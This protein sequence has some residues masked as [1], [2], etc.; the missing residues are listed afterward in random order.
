MKTLIKAKHCS[1]N[2]IF[3]FLRLKNTNNVFL[4]YVKDFETNG[5]SNKYSSCMI[6]YSAEKTNNANDYKTNSLFYIH[7][8]I[9]K[10]N[11]KTFLFHKSFNFNENI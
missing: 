10:I 7:H 1:S 8:Q 11:Y 4:E 3:Y 2:S 9:I 5:Y 6:L